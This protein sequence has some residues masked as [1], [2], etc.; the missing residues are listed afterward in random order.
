MTQPRARR[1]FSWAI[2]GRLARG[3]AVAFMLVW[4]VGLVAW[5]ERHGHCMSCLTRSWGTGD[6]VKHWSIKEDGEGVVVVLEVPDGGPVPCSDPA[7]CP[8]DASLLLILGRRFDRYERDW[9]RRRQRLTVIDESPGRWT[10]ILDDDEQ[11]STEE[12]P[13]LIYRPIVAPSCPH[14]NES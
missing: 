1:R 10:D 13:T 9:A 8:R 2:A 14:P 6:D 7:T 3:V 5:P 4:L 12:A 11:P